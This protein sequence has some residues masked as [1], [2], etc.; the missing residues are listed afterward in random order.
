MLIIAEKINKDNEQRI[1]EV[2]IGWRNQVMTLRNTLE[3]VKEQM[4]N[5]AQQKI[6]NLIEQHRAE[7]GN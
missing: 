4:E 6:Q 2:E 5:E 7:L 1:R 3:V